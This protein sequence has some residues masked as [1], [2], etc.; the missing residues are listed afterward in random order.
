MSDTNDF[1]EQAQQQYQ[2]AEEF[3]TNSMRAWNE[4]V[5]TSTDMAFD[6][7]LKNWNYSQTLRDSVEQ[8][9]VEPLKTQRHVA[10]QALE[11][12]IKTQRS[13]TREMMQFWQG[14]AENATKK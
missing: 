2:R 12:V 1:K 3:T 9:M 14:M 4:L 10:E 13:L 11:D 7:V 5:A 6:M 8:S